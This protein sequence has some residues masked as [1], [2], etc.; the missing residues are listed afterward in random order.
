MRVSPEKGS[1]PVWAADG[2]ELFYVSEKGEMMSV[3]LDPASR[4]VGRPLALFNC[5]PF[6]TYFDVDRQGRFLM[7]TRHKGRR[8]VMTLNWL[9]ELKA[10]VPPAR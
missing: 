7:L 9:E 5:Q 6:E 1:I 10:K 3:S 2:R 4:S 8:L